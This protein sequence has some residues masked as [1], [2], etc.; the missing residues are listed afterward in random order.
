MADELL[1]LM[2]HLA[3]ADE[4]TVLAFAFRAGAVIRDLVDLVKWLAIPYGDNAPMFATADW[5]GEPLEDGRR[6]KAAWVSIMGP[7]EP[8][9]PHRAW[10]QCPTCGVMQ[11]IPV[12]P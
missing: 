5:S 2:G 4:E 9:D 6:L 11:T 7:G 1:E 10:T 8:P 3:D 12:K